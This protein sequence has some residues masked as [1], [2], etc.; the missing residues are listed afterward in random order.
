MPDTLTPT[1]PIYT[2][3]GL[4]VVLAHDVAPRFGYTTGKLN[5]RVRGNL[6]R[7]GDDYAFQLTEAEWTALISENGI[8][9]TGRGGIRHTPWAF[10][11][12]GVVMA[13][14]LLRS[15]EAVAAS[16][17]IVAT[18]VEARHRAWDADAGRNLHDPLGTADLVPLARSERAGLAAKLDGALGRVLDAI[19][20]PE[21][22]TTVREEARSIARE[23]LG[24]IRARLR[25]E[26]LTNERAIAEIGKLLREAEAL[27]AEIEARRIETEHRHLAFLAKQLRLVLE[28]QRYLDGGTA[29]GLLGVLKDLG[30]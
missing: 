17:L 30:G 20:D 18:F 22:G 19:A 25:R 3:R 13:A 7:F 24:A 5:E 12:H 15:D 14:T 1:L 23:G 8:S 10:T 4:A 9:N 28:A 27:D 26:G 6:D 29:D 16:R 2:V 21:A 11:E